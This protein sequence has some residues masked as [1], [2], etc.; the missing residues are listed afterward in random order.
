MA[1]P[2]GLASAFLVMVTR[3]LRLAFR[4]WGQI[5]NPLFFFVIVTT[6]FPLGISPEMSLLR[7]IGAGVVW[8]AALL[9]SLLALDNL[10]RSDMEDG[11]MEQ[12]VLSPQPLALV[13]LAK[14]MTHWLVSGLPLVLVAPVVAMSLNI[15]R[16]ALGTLM[17]ALALGTPT[18]SLIGAVGAALTVGLQRSGALL[19]LLVLPLFVP[20]LIL[21]ARAT[22]MAVVGEDP[23]GILY[24]LAAM[25]M[26]SVSLTPFATSAAIRISLD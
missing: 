18:L 21:G 2:A 1:N 6:L 10:F 23:G 24:L 13:L 19:A 12:L 9:S 3:D 22:D 5:A 25:L 14:T 17:L 26:A 11:S 8:V 15:P 16:D 20:V 4:R 7:D